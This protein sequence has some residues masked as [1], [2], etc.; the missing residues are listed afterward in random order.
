MLLENNPYPQDTRVSLEAR[1]LVEAGYHVSVIAPRAPGQPLVQTVEGVRTYRFPAPPVA[2]GL[3]GYVTEYALSMLAAL[4]LSVV[5][6]RREGFDVI[7]AHNP[8]DTFFAIAVPYK[9][10]GKRFVFDHHD[11]SPELY[12]ARF[13][14][15]AS[16]LVYHALLLLERLTYRWADHVITTNESYKRVAM[17]RGRVPAD[18]ITIVRNGPDLSQIPKPAP[19]SERAK[20]AK[21]AI[22]YVG[23]MGT[24][25]GVDYLV[26][27]LGHLV[28]DLGRTDVRAVIIGGGDALDGLKSLSNRLG[29]NQYIRFT[30]RVSHADAL[31]HLS[32]ADICAVPDPSNAY[33]DRST[34][35]KIMEY[36][37]LGKPTVAFDLPEHHRSAGTSAL[38]VP[39]NDEFEFAC[40]LRDLMD[41]PALRQTM[42]EIG[43]RRVEQELGW[44]HSAPKLVHAYSKLF[45]APKQRGR[46]V[47]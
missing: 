47:E 38:Y 8:P 39:A 6:L 9:L 2:D 34:M 43:R 15:D 20:S 23:Q 45:Q 7:H 19:D 14:G 13:G 35:I 16:R 40:A 5:V 26:R 12:Y 10:L 30:G 28:H 41:D 24:Q 27:A 33:N 42:G 31:N 46:A 17:Q 25:D 32:E 4:V 1:M 11:L 22:A 44:H 37:A 29:L 36:M 21:A 18:R 3:R